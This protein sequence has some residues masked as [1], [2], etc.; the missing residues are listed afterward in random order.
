MRFAFSDDQLAIRDAV[1]AFLADTVTSE[2]TRAAMA[3]GS[4]FD[5]LLWGAMASEL[6]LTG[7]AIPEDHGGS[8]LGAVET[9]IVSEALGAHVAAVPWL[10]S[11]VLATRAILLGGN[12]A[13][14]AAWLPRLADGSAIVTF[15]DGDFMHDGRYLSGHAAFVP[16]GTIAD[17]IIVPVGGAVFLVP[18]D[19][20]EVSL[21]ARTSLDQTRPLAALTLTG[22]EAVPL[23]ALDWRAIEPIGWT[24]LAADALGGAQATLDRTVAYVRERTQ[25]GRTIGSFQ[26]IKH[27]LADMLIAIEQARSA[28]YWAAGEIDADSADARFAAHAAKS[29]ACDT[30]T[31]CAGHAIQLH[32]GIGFTWEHDV[33]LFFKR[34]RA[35]MSLLGAPAWHREQIARAMSLD[36]AC[37]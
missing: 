27:R 24:A 8:A 18:T 34:A 15:A 25:F 12:D 9:A 17:A 32:G 19:A 21:A 2:R 23:P 30:Y 7:I 33:H 22:A 31:E 28:V 26:V 6:G 13:L 3:D 20:P 5:R 14:R 37:A 36:V 11:A 1:T 16:H 10:A 4:G 35:D 29:F